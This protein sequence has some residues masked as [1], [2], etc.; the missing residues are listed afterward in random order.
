MLQTLC[1]PF[2]QFFINKVTQ[3]LSQKPAFCCYDHIIHPQKIKAVKDDDMV[4]DTSK[5]LPSFSS[6]GY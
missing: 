6:S 5:S 2:S 1:F 3:T 4:Y